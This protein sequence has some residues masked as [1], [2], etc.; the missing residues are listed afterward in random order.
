L[1]NVDAH[2]AALVTR[3]AAARA[4]RNADA[5]GLAVAARKMAGLLNADAHGVAVHGSP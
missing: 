2:E 3:E 5:L 4:L 1:F